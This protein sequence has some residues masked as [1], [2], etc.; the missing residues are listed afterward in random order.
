PPKN[1]LCCY[2]SIKCRGKFSL[3]HRH[4]RCEQLMIELAADTGSNLGNLLHRSETVEPRHQRIVQRRWDRQRREW[5]GECVPIAGLTEHP[6]FK[7]CFRKL[8]REKRHTFCPLQDLPE[9]LDGKCFAL[10]DPVDKR[11]HLCLW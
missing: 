7:H 9:D 4:D 8:L 10:G 6:G 2:Q 1:K 3:W 11:N 5:P